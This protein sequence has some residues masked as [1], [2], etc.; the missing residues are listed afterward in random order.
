MHLL[1]RI[2][3]LHTRLGVWHPQ[4]LW[5]RSKGARW[6]CPCCA[7]WIGDNTP[8]STKVDVMDKKWVLVNRLAAAMPGEGVLLDVRRRACTLGA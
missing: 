2:K 4:R 5:Y 3:N 7:A 6:K 8:H 1:E